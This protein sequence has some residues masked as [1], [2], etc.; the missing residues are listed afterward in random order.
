MV[1]LS[2][3]TTFL[4]VKHRLHCHS[5][6]SHSSYLFCSIAIAYLL[7]QEALKGAIN[8]TDAQHIDTV[9]IFN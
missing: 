4:V 2:Y 7:L 5:F 1:S 6:S 3:Q 9:I 8:A